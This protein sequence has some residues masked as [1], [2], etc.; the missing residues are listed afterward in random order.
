M[1]RLLVAGA[2]ALCAGVV[3]YATG[4]FVP[5]PGR[6]FSLTALIVGLAVVVGLTGR[7]AAP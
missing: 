7:E 5:Y 6:S 3:G 1:D 4:L 2:A